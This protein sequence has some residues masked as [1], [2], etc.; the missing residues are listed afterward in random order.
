MARH[1]EIEV[2]SGPRYLATFEVRAE[3]DEPGGA[4]VMSEG[5]TENVGPEGTLV[6]LPKKLPEVGSRVRLEVQGED[7]NKLQVVAEVLRIERNP[8]HPLAAL[9]LLG[10]TD[11]WK[12][13][14]WE[15]AAPRVAP[16]PP[17]PSEDED[18]DDEDEFELAN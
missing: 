13:L 7:G 12:G 1:M 17:P 4:H 18:E 3:W 6:H 10:E 2:R 11:E 16:P 9:Q 5:I 14:I 15:P 8:G